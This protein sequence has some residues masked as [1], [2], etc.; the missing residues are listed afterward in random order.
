MVCGVS[1]CLCKLQDIRNHGTRSVKTS[2]V[3]QDTTGPRFKQIKF[4][5]FSSANDQHLNLEFSNRS[6]HSI[7]KLFAILV[8]FYDNKMAKKQTK[9]IPEAIL[10]SF[11]DEPL[12]VDKR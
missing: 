1:V 9:R 7:F 3:Q 12:L 11:N 8:R 5:L 10:H 2:H 4:E 6:F